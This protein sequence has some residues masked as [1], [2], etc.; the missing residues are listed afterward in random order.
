[1]LDLFD[2]GKRIL[3]VDESWLSDSMFIRKKYNQSGTSNSVEEQVIQPRI[4]IIGAVDT[5]GDVYLSLTQVNT[6]SEI[7]KLFL[8]K[9]AI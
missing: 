9:L 1:M 8:S 7:M 2:A 3:S 4:S 6:N 5:E